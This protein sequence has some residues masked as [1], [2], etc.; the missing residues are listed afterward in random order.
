MIRWWMAG[1]LLAV[2]LVYAAAGWGTSSPSDREGHM[3]ISSSAF[4]ERG[5]IPRRHTC[6]GED[7][8]PP[9]AFH[10]LPANTVSLA[11]IVEDP[12]APRGTFDHWIAWNILPTGRG[13]PEGVKLSHQGTNH[14]GEIRY[15][16]P[17]PPQGKKHHYF[18]KLFALDTQLPLSPGA[19][20]EE[21][22]DAMEGHILDE[23]ELVGL[24]QR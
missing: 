10:D 22:E 6:D 20:K 1:S 18:F 16:G 5:T 15:R 13:L 19:N 4:Q 11:L 14:F 12:D 3:K 21:L 23:A 17:C 8:S 9:L 24:Y 7:L 2:V